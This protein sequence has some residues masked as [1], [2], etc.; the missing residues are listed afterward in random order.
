MDNDT[1]TARLLYH[2]PLTVCSG[3][4]DF[5]TIQSAIDAA[6]PGDTIQVC[7]G[8]YPEHLTIDKSLTLDG[9][10]QGINPNT[11]SRVSEAD[12]VEPSS[13]APTDDSCDTNPACDIN[14]SASNVTN[15]ADLLSTVTIHRPLPERS[16]GPKV[17]MSTPRA[18][19]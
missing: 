13:S 18:R 11:G 14:I 3:S 16:M 17:S 9:L 5:N 7:A 19:T 1:E 10:N 2:Q 8:V 6:S 15:G 12:I 4:G